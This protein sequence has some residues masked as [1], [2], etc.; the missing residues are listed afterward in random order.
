M[1]SKKAEE[2]RIKAEEAEA[3]AVQMKAFPLVENEWK[4]D[5]GSRRRQ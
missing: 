2:Y 4:V 1:T 3:Q 5:V